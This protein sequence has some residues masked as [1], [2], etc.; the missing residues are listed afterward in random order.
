[1]VAAEFSQ[2]RLTPHRRLPHRHARHRACRE[3]NVH[4]RTETDQSK[5]LAGGKR[6]SGL[7][8]A[9]DAPSHQTGDLHHG[10]RPV[11]T[12]YDQ[13]IALVLRARLVQLG[14]EETACPMLDPAYASPHGSPVHMA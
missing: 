7:D 8:P 3:V 11:R 13:A 5:T 6:R 1:M 14:I 9:E 2:D 4:P 10:N 12:V